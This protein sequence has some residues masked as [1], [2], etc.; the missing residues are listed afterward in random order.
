MKNKFLHFYLAIALA[1]IYCIA[2]SCS[3]SK[4]VEAKIEKIDSLIQW[5]NDCL[6]HIELDLSLKSRFKLY[7]TD[8]LYVFLKL[9]T[10]TGRID[11][12][13][14]SLDRKTEFTLV[15]NPDD[16][17]MGNGY[18]SGSFELV[19][20]QNMYQFMLLDKTNGRT[21]HVQ[22]GVIEDQRWIRAIE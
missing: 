9:D 16:L 14:W 5:N 13:Q 15:L 21:W 19:P 18:G 22:W 2:S 8:N 11:L 17:T 20:T 3:Q 4:D 1:T 10:K 6:D 12:V 7:K